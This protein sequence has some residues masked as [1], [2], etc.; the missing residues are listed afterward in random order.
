MQ[1][2]FPVDASIP[3]VLLQDHDDDIRAVLEEILSAVQALGVQFAVE[4]SSEQSLQHW[5]ELQ[6]KYPD[7]LHVISKE[8]CQ[9]PIFDME[10]MDDLTAE[11]LK[12]FQTTPRVPIAESGTIKN[13]DPI[14]ET[15]NGFVFSSKN[16]WSLLVA[17]VRASETYRFPYDWKNLVKAVKK[18]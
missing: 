7:V 16:P 6:A 4:E 11:K 10:L 12:T 17:L 9:D 2:G 14:A 5:L 13:F 3:L 18:S 15:G 1:W 8:E